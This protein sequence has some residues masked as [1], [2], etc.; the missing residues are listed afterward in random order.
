MLVCPVKKIISKSF[1]SKKIIKIRIV[2]VQAGISFQALF[3]I[4]RPMQ[5]NNKNYK[6]VDT[7]EVSHFNKSSIGKV[8]HPMMHM[9][10]SHQRRYNSSQITNWFLGFWQTGWLRQMLQKLK[11][12]RADKREHHKWLRKKNR[13]WDNSYSFKYF[14]HALVLQQLNTG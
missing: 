12:W 1:H 7:W 8:Q 9:N 13:W 5:T 11:R 10:L 2:N 6:K 4:T 3:F 14:K